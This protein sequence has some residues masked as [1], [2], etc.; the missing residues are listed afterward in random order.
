MDLSLLPPYSIILVIGIIK[1]FRESSWRNRRLR[2]ILSTEDNMYFF[3]DDGTHG[4]ELWKSDGTVAGTQLI[5]DVNPGVESAYSSVI[6]DLKGVMFEVGDQILFLADDGVHG[7][8]LWVTDG[9]EDGTNMLMDVYPGSKNGIALST[10]HSAYVMNDILFFQGN[11]EEFGRE[12]WRSDGTAAGTYMIKNIRYLSADSSPYDFMEF[13]GL[14][15]FA[16]QEGWIQGGLGE[17]LY[18]TDGTEAG[19][20]IVKD[21][22]PQSDSSSPRGLTPVGNFFYFITDD[23][24]GAGLWRSD[25]TEAGTT[26]IKDG[27]EHIWEDRIIAK[28]DDLFFAASDGVNGFEIWKSDGTTSGTFMIKDINTFGG[29]SGS[30]PHDLVIINDRVYFIAQEVNNEDRLWVTDGTEAGTMMVSDMYAGSLTVFNDELIFAGPSPSGSG[31]FMWHSD[32]TTAGTQLV[33]GVVSD[34]EFN[35]PQSYVSFKDKLYFVAFDFTSGRELWVYESGFT[36][37]I[38]KVN[39]ADDF[40]I[41][42]NPADQFVNLDFNDSNNRT[43]NVYNTIGQIVWSKKSVNKSSISIEVNEFQ[44]GIY[45]LEIIDTKDNIRTKQFVVK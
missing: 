26:L 17:E 34:P 32:G 19:T 11:N 45:F 6:S 9:T 24:L 3:A 44:S 15:Y 28:G 35:K 2:E 10:K 23:G 14:L 12:L 42:P 8:E 36:S 5:K 29:S 20:H 41:S 1:H 37:S 13:N 18:V 22:D 31:Q 43:I 39:K 30:L 33:N 40:V 38:A 7:M 21:I 16:A 25:G 4:F 27:F